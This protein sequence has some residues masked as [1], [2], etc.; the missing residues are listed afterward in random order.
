M[1]INESPEGLL[2][3]GNNSSIARLSPSLTP[4]WNRAERWRAVVTSVEMT[5]LSDTYQAELSALNA[6]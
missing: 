6:L 1:I 4:S 3:Q 5:C 2:T